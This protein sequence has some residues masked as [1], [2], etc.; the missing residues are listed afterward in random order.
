MSPTEAALD[1]VGRIYEAAA[2]PSLWPRVLEQFARDTGGA[3]AGFT[4]GDV[5]CHSLE[6]AYTA[7][8]AEPSDTPEFDGYYRSL[9]L[10]AAKGPECRMSIEA[11]SHQWLSRRDISRSPFANEFLRHQNLFHNLG[12]IVT[13]EPCVVSIVAFRPH[14]WGAFTGD[15]CDLL[16][17]LVPHFRRAAKLSSLLVPLQA[18]CSVL[19][20][21]TIGVF[22][23]DEHARILQ[24]NK[25][26]RRVIDTADG[27]IIR[28]N[29]LRAL[30]PVENA[31]IQA[32]IQHVAQA[33]MEAT[34]NNES[35]ILVRR[36]SGKRAY[37]VFVRPLHSNQIYSGQQ[38]TGAIVFVL[39]PEDQLEVSEAVVR[40]IW[41]LTQSEA[42]LACAL[43]KGQDLRDYCDHEAISKHTAR[44]HLKRVFA[45]LGVK[46]QPELISV[47]SR[48]VGHFR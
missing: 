22:I 33:S 5:V 30:M 1:L 14:H 9:S 23:V 6:T 3:A 7:G 20:A 19:D 29:H 31:G 24:T 10:Y 41:G 44:T 37:T 13:E 17:L 40:R 34:L 21:L 42:H 15:S 12:A 26:A 4:V 16:N 18:G 39:D 27:L 11:S 47:L 2:D 46:R 25:R 45:K 38:S 43:L 48:T 36:S 32:A 8:V 35:V 28:T